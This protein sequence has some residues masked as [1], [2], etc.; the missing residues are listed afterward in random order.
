M[1]IEADEQIN[2]R[3][4][5][6]TGTKGIVVL[7]VHPG[8]AAEKAGLNGVTETP[9]GIILGDIIVQA[10]DVVQLTMMHQGKKTGPDPILFGL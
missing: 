9:Q 4:N 6:I 1:G 5:V 10:S 2:E 3:L 8:S 7:R